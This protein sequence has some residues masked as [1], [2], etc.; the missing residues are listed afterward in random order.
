MRRTSAVSGVACVYALAMAG[1]ATASPFGSTVVSYS[2]GGG[3]NAS[4]NDPSVALGEPSRF[5]PGE[6]GGAV[7]PFAAPF[8]GSQVVSVGV[9]GQLTVGFTQPVMDDP[10]NPF[11]VDLLVF[12]NSF[13]FDPATFGP[14]ANAVFGGRGR[15]E[16]SAD[17][18]GWTV[19]PGFRPDG[20]FPTLGYGDLSDPYSPTAGGVLTD[21]TRPVD[22]S[23]AWQGLGMSAMV[24][25][26]GGSGGG[27]G[28]DIGS[29]GL[30]SI[31]FVRVTVPAG[32]T[33]IVNIDGFSDVA[34]IP[35]PGTLG[36]LA[37]A[38]V[39]ARRRRGVR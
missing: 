8:R 17:G 7:T 9:G 20:V 11:G 28:V 25:G 31:S 33:G 5:T 4:F 18:V 30:S 37:L 36:V 3:T 15:L 27:A 39:A 13:F 26:Y 38:G 34:A 1:A 12:G 2:A 19:V 16:V 32:E 23:F 29:L 6:F 10:L 21:F 14:T 24:A 35:T 22:P